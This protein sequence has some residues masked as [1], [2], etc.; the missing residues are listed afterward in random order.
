MKSTVV[1]NEE[2]NRLC[3]DFIDVGY[4]AEDI[5]VVNY[6]DKEKVIKR[7][8]SD[9]AMTVLISF[10]DL[11]T[12]FVKEMLIL[13]IFLNQAEIDLHCYLVMDQKYDGILPLKNRFTKLRIVF[14]ALDEFGPM[15]GTKIVEG[16]LQ[17]KLTKALFLI[18]KDGAVFYID[19]P[20]DISTPFDL[21]RLKIELNKAYASYTGVGCHG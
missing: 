12:E 16:S 14:D 5:S 8:H 15:Y 7:S 11:S 3:E 19:M 6:Y 4:M 13:D 18:S 17:D 10:P 21:E 1:Y 9:R 20:E 2:S